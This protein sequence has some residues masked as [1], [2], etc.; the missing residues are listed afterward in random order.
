MVV[1]P[2]GGFLMGSTDA[3]IRH[4]VS[5]E[6][7]KQQLYADELPR[8]EVGIA[9]A[10]AVGRYEVTRQEYAAFAAATERGEG[11][12]CH[13]YTGTEWQK[14]VSRNWRAPGYAQGDG[15]PVVCVSWHDA[16]AYVAWLS[17]E[18]GQSYR[19][20][21]EA[22][23]EYAARAGTAGLRYWDEADG[24][25][26]RHANAADLATKSRYPGW[27]VVACDD[28]AVHTAAVGRYGANGFGLHDMLGNVWEWTEDCY[29]DNYTGAPAD[30]S[31]WTSGACGSRI[32]RGGS[33]FY[34]PEYI[35][36]AGRSRVVAGNRGYDIGFR[37]ARALD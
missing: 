27:A 20:L 6:G 35:R 34:L 32:L 12:G 29:H 5:N 15:E 31:A 2:S 22:E 7:G 13:V 11:D 14:Q 4:L 3:D 18:T 25:Q 23:W 30:Q 26:C 36:A 8:H 9:R 16:K 1:L 17:R 10:L 21:S 28:G 24:S 37:V 33:W 19:L